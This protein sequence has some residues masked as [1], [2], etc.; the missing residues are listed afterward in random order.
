M[1]PDRRSLNRARRFFSD[2]NFLDA[3]RSLE[4][5][6][7]KFLSI[8]L[9]IVILASLFDLGVVLAQELFS[10]PYAR[11]ST[12]LTRIFGLFLNV[13]IALELLENITAYLKKQSLQV[14]LVVVT[15]LIAASR[16]II[17]L[18]LE[19]TAGLDLIALGFTIFAIS[20]SYWIVRRVSP[21]QE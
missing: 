6:V 10:Y 20:L 12:S 3:L 1:E 11:L 14:E 15:A 5:F 16:K 9:V 4:V 13:L 8:A 18:D 7:S 2:A 19:K 17:I 21:R